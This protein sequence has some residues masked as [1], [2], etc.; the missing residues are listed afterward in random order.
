VGFGGMAML[1][2]AGDGDGG[3]GAATRRGRGGVI[4]GVNTPLFR[5]GPQ[6]RVWLVN[7]KANNTEQ[8]CGKTKRNNNE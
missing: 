7:S 6:L 5:L 4:S 8:L 1:S 3:G 2:A